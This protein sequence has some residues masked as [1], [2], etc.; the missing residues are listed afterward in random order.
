MRS[1]FTICL[2]TAGLVTYAQ[3]TSDKTKDNE[4]SLVCVPIGKESIPSSD[5]NRFL[6]R[7]MSAVADS[8][9]GI[10]EIEVGCYTI[11]FNF[12]IDETGMLKDFKVVK[13]EYGAGAALIKKLQQYTGKWTPAYSNGKNVRSYRKQSIQFTI[14]NDIDSPGGELPYPPVSIRKM[15]IP[16]KMPAPGCCAD[17]IKVEQR[18]FESDGNSGRGKPIEQTS[19]PLAHGGV[20]TITIHDMKKWRSYLQYALDTAIENY[21]KIPPGEYT[22]TVNMIIDKNGSLLSATIATDPGHNIAQHLKSIIEKYPGTRTPATHN[23]RAV[24]YFCSQ[25]VVYKIGV[26][27]GANCDR[28]AEKKD[29]L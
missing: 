6:D 19:I 12:A 28:S 23:G 21:T 2:L 14:D 17:I 13:D 22:A 24:K 20:E 11:T 4:G 3:N 15:D 16:A 7:T 8:I 29:P 9:T 10:G 18:I 27:K 25:T 1:I 5:W 26:E